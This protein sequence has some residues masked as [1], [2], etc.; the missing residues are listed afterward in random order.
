MGARSDDGRDDGDPFIGASFEVESL[1]YSK[2][3]GRSRT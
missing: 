3:I 1:G 2:T